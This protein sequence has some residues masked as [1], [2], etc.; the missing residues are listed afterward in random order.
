MEKISIADGLALTVVAM[1]VVLIVLTS[2]WGFVELIAKLLATSG[3]PIIKSPTITK[4]PITQMIE[5]PEYKKVAEI[6]ALISA[7]KDKPNIKF[8]IVESKRIK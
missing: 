2:I 4:S 6:I 8:E 3:E 7:S 5:N 1:L